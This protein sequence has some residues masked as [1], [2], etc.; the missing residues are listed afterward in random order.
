[1]YTF[2]T[3]FSPALIWLLIWPERF[4]TGECKVLESRTHGGG[5]GKGCLHAHAIFGGSIRAGDNI[6][7][8][9]SNMYGGTCYG[10]DLGSWVS[11][12]VRDSMSRQQPDYMYYVWKPP[13][14]IHVYRL[15]YK[16]AQR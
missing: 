2:T 13:S 8:Y 5:L 3:I 7:P 15:A 11:L 1:M 9:L 12:H 4:E 10:I 14:Y 6:S 16:C